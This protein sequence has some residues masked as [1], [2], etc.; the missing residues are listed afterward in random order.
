MS[1]YKLKKIERTNASDYK[2]WK[3]GLKGFI[4]ATIFHDPDFLGYHGTKFNEYHIGVFKGEEL[5]GIIPL[6]IVDEG[7]KLVAKSPYGASYGGFIFRNVLNYSD[8]KEIIKKFIGFMESLNVDSIII[9]PSLPVYHEYYSDTFIFSML[10]NGFKFHNSDITSIV[11]LSR[12]NK[13][14]FNTRTKRILKKINTEFI[15]INYDAP[16]DDFYFLVDKT[17]Q[18]HGV[19]PTHTKEELKYLKDI[20]PEQIKFPVAYYKNCPVAGIGEFIINKRVVMSFYICQDDYY[21]KLNIQT[22]L[23]KNLLD[24]AFSKKYLFYD[25][26]TSSVNMQGRENIFMFKEGLGA[27]GY[28]RHTYILHI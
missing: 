27:L 16:L 11:T 20:F 2:K 5:F 8:S 25:F 22:Y 9:T 26:G 14:N 24:N 28:F 6:A 15:E 17:F 7:G 1:K 18:K 10:E 3:S 23:I 12:D 21:K 13:L 4:G 19:S